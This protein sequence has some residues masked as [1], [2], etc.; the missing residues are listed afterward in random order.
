MGYIY[1]IQMTTN[2]NGENMSNTTETLI[3]HKNNNL[4]DNIKILTH[5]IQ[6][7]NDKLKMQIWLEYCHKNN[8][9]IISMTE[10]KLAESTHTKFKLSNPYYNIYTSNCTSKIAK[11][12]ESS[13]SIAI[14]IFKFLQP[15]IYNIITLAE[16]ALAIDFFFLQ[17]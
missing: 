7:A 16:T 13:M 5:N 2:L 4:L 11:K 9:N 12:Q 10:T 3:Q 17:S 8:F 15:Y 6:G 14:V 1:I